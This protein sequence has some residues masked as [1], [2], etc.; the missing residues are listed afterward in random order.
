MAIIGF[1]FF[2]L[3]LI[4]YSSAMRWLHVNPYLTWITG[5][6]VQIMLLFGFAMLGWLRLG[7]WLVT[8]FGVILLILRLSLGYFGKLAFKYEGWHLFDGWMIVLGLAMAS[9]LIHSPLI[10]YDN[11][12]HWATIVKFLTYT[13]HLPGAHDAIISFT[14][15][16]PATALFITQFVTFVGFNA[17]TMLVA[18]FGL[19]WAASYAIFA[20]LRD[21]TRGLNSMLLCL[22]IAISYVFNINIR[23][24]NLLVD[25][26]LA[27]LT[28]AALVGIFIYR[29][30]PRIQAAHVA[31]F[32]GSLLLVKNSAA[33]F[34]ALIAGYYLYTLFT[35]TPAGPWFKR[36]IKL[37]ATFL[38]TILVAALPFIWW[39]IH[40]HLTFTNSKHEISAQAYQS[41]LSQDGWQGFL[42]IGQQFVHQIFNLGSL[43][44]QGLLG[45]NLLLIGA[46]A[47]IK[48]GCHHPNNLF[49][50]LGWLDL[51]SLL[52]YF[53]LLGMYVFSM[54][55]AEAITLDGFERYMSTVVVLNLLIGAIWLVRVMDETFYEQDF[56]HRSPEAFRSIITKTTYQ[57]TTFLML[58]FAVIMMYSEINGT[59]FTNH[60]NRRTLPVKLT[61]IAQPW[62]HLN[63]TKLLI[64]DPQKVEVTTYY[65]GYLANYYFFTSNA[66]GQAVFSKSRTAF[67]QNLSQYDYVAIPKYDQ[68]FT[69]GIHKSYHQTIR[70]GFYRIHAHRLQKLSAQ[71]VIH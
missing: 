9:V 56:A 23:L 11:F 30:R 67:K 71:Q 8:S 63:K 22:A 17:G 3:A 62:T 24:N 41:Q 6:L 51:I 58:F 13:G 44:T 14:S 66:T 19:I 53:S 48:Y 65:A 4:G 29:N 33:F 12:S 21:R 10:H 61:K 64:V 37:S 1:I 40:V 18:Q 25:Y 52:Y 31:L 27:I 54:P 2:S 5:I 50:H 16:P 42:K 32:S 39:E 59:N 26:V 20:T 60:Y 15:Y 28:M 57:L 43:S 70:T 35:Q 7:I 38:G 69:L 36:T 34:V 45:L 46:W 47:I 49:K 68:S 55:Y